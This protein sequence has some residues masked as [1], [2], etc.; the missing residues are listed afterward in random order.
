MST[1]SLATPAFAPI[2]RGFPYM[3]T[4]IAPAMHHVILLPGF[5]EPE[6]LADFGQRQA[7]VN[8]LVTSVVFHDDFCLWFPGD[9]RGFKSN[10]IPQG[11]FV[12]EQMAPVEPLPSTKELSARHMDLTRFEEAQRQGPWTT[13]FVGDISKG[14][15]FPTPEEEKRLAGTHADGIPKGLLPCLQCGEWRG[16][17]FDTIFRELVV[18]VHC[19][20]ENDSRCA[21]CGGL[22]HHWKLNANYFDPVDRKIWHVPGFAALDHLCPPVKGACLSPRIR[23]AE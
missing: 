2:F 5:W 18:R 6:I 7:Q 1:E 9:G 13:I 12:S 20:C 16:E 4:Q 8:K 15:W 22:F 10:E 21:G 17:C 23:Q 14:G 3:T 11:R 19:T